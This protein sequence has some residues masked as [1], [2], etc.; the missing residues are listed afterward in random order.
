MESTDYLKAVSEEKQSLSSKKE[1][2]KEKVITDEKI[3]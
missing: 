3:C 2:K 1:T